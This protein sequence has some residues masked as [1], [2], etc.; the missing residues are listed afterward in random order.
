MVVDVVEA[1][2]MDAVEATVA[3][4]EV[5]GCGVDTEAMETDG[6]LDATDVMELEVITRAAG[7]FEPAVEVTSVEEVV[8]VTDV[9][10]TR[11]STDPA[12][13][14]AAAADA[15]KEASVIEAKFVFRGMSAGVGRVTD[16]GFR[17]NVFTT[18]VVGTATVPLGF[19][20]VGLAKAVLS[21]TTFKSTFFPSVN[22]ADGILT[23]RA[24]EDTTVLLPPV[25][26]CDT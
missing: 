1:V 5:E 21:L 3:A 7:T 23:I 24:A 10:D 4:S 25:K 18:E 17:E 15:A 14:L 13:A 2:D 6:I 9:V 11:L 20:V 8:V 22:N 19:A 16:S 26:G 12:E